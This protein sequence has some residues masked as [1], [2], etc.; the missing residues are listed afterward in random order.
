MKHQLLSPY[1]IKACPKIRQTRVN[2]LIES[3]ISIGKTKTI[4]FNLSARIKTFYSQVSDTNC[5]NCAEISHIEGDLTC[6]YKEWFCFVGGTDS[7]LGEERMGGSLCRELLWPLPDA[8]HYT[9]S[10]YKENNAFA[11]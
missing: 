11:L 1:K 10:I 7:V 6:I 8:E 9:F 5:R 4:H 3:L 2:V